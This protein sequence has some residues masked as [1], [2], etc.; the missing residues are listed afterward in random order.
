MSINETIYRRL[1]HIMVENRVTL[2]G[3][4]NQEDEWKAQWS[5]KPDWDI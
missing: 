5:A 4:Q 1:R 2:N 3:T